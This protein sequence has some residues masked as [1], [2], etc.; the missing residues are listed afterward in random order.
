MFLL[1]FLF[2]KY[3][4]KFIAVSNVF[5]DLFSITIFVLSIFWKKFFDK[6]SASLSI[7]L[8]VF[9]PDIYIGIFLFIEKTYAL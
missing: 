7:F 6:I 1:R 8:I 2:S 9:P 4:S 3:C 5:I